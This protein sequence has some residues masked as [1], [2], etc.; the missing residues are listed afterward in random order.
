MKNVGNQNYEVTKSIDRRKAIKIIT[1]G[2][3]A[4]T[5][6]NLFPAKWG[7]P[8]VESIF[9]PVHAA[10]SG[11]EA[12]EETVVISNFT[13]T[14][15]GSDYTVHSITV[16]VSQ[17]GSYRLDFYNDSAM[18]SLLYS[19]TVVINDSWTGSGGLGGGHAA[20][21]GLWCRATNTSDPSL[22]G[23]LQATLV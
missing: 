23:T 18:T 16:T 20:G 21:D 17:D 3:V 11:P 4:V 22:S 8:V 1:G 10:T 5:A 7:V 13:A 6:F 19:T 15:A 12:P 14:F 2:V 9:L